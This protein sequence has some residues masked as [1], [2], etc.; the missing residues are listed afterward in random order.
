MRSGWH[1]ACLGDVLAVLKNGLNCKQDKSGHGQRISRIESISSASFDLARVG[2]AEISDHDRSKFRLL[3]G[4]ILFSHINSPVHVGK[5]AV[6]DFDEEVYHGVNLLLMRPT[7]AVCGAYLELYL[8]YLFEQGYWL[9]VCKQSV[10]QASV[11]QQD[12]SRVPIAYP[13]DLAEQRRIVAILDEAFEAIATAK[14]NA[15]KNLQNA[16]GVFE[17]YLEQLLSLR[18]SSW[19]DIKLGDLCQVKTGKKDVNQGNPEGQFPFFTC[20]AEHTYSDSYSFDTEALLIA[21]NGNVGQ[22]SYYSGK[23][24][25]YQRTYVLSGFNGVHAKYMFRVLDKRFGAMVSKQK[26][27][28]TMPYIK[29]GMITDFVVPVPSLAEQQRIIDEL[30]SVASATDRLKSLYLAKCDALI[31]L[32]KSLLH[33]AFTGQL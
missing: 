33:Q 9:S 24:E 10:N 19:G 21:G 6:F 23:F 29:V 8:K 11:N 15:E 30:D 20:A 31:E 17:N 5:T 26:L 12:I 28:N 14:A 3:R 22:V 16:R 32:K 4:D 2:Y 25:A 13:T 27:G 18:Q 1:S 7:P